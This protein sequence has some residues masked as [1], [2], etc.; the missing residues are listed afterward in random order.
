MQIFSLQDSDLDSSSDP[1]KSS[2][3]PVD[4][5]NTHT[6]S[7]AQSPKLA[8]KLP[9]PHPDKNPHPTKNSQITQITAG[10][11]NPNRL[12]IHLDHQFAFSLTLPQVVDEKLKIGTTLTPAQVTRLQNLSEFGKLYQN[13]LEWVLVRPRSVKETRDFLERKR[14]KREW[15]SARSFSSPSSPTSPLSASPAPPSSPPSPY[16]ASKP[17]SKPAKVSPPFP[18]EFIDQ[19]LNQLLSKSYLDDQ[20]FATFYLANRKLKQGISTKVLRSEL[21]QKGVADDIIV[22]SLALSSRSE[23]EDIQKI[24]QKKSAKYDSRRLAQYLLRRGFD[25]DLVQSALSEMD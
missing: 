15:L 5:P 6:A 21:R 16:S 2:S 23:A 17:S 8:S 7:D 9:T 19:I 13:T 1:I 20:K 4:P 22:Q 3:N 11:K 18:P 14:R 24:I 10:V 25:P 12:N